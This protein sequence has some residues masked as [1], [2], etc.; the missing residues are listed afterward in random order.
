VQKSEAKHYIGSSRWWNKRPQ[1]L[2]SFIETDPKTIQHIRS[3]SEISRNQLRVSCTPGEDKT[4]HIKDS[5]KLHGNTF[6]HSHSLHS[7][8]LSGRYL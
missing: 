2:F 7:A 3:L 5:R 6:C 8:I 4:S 1:A